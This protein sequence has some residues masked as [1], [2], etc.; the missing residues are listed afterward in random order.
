VAA[1]AVTAETFGREVLGS[2]QPVIVDFWA[3]WCGPCLAVAPLLEQI[4]K[5][6]QGELRVVKVN[7]DEEPELAVRF[8]I[9]SIPTILLFRDGGPVA[10]SVGAR[11]KTQLESALGLAP[12]PRSADHPGAS[13]LRG[14]LA[15]LGRDGS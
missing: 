3:P 6:R 5:E 2:E 7:V 11:G 8:G 13:G 14:R 1:S 12:A 10:G 9:A 15:R 4:A